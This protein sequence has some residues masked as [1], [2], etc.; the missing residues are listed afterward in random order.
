[1]ASLSE[2]LTGLMVQASE[3][4]GPR[5]EFRRQRNLGIL[6]TANSNRFFPSRVV[7]GFR[8]HDLVDFIFVG[9]FERFIHIDKAN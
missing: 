3:K 6:R 8:C 5:C 1:M 9:S 4:R 2:N 7:I